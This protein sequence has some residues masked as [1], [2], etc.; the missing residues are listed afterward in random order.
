V[1]VDHER[2]CV[3]T[4]EPIDMPFWL[5]SMG[6]NEQCA[7]WKWHFLRVVLGHMP[8]VADILNFFHYGQHRMLSLYRLRTLN[9][10]NFVSN[11]C[12]EGYEADI[13]LPNGDYHSLH[14]AT[15][16]AFPVFYRPM[17]P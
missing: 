17:S 13:F 1:S 9:C 7:R 16:P 14:S 6:P 15:G 8:R 2:E 12:N 4:V 10:S 3:K 5:D 11:Q